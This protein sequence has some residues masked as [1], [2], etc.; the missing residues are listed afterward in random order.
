MFMGR[1][2]RY[3]R[4]VAIPDDCVVYVDYG[5][6]A[7]SNCRQSEAIRDKIATVAASMPN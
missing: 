5:Q 1:S 7:S 3:E 4:R 6:S 2:S